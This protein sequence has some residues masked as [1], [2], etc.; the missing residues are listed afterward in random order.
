MQEQSFKKFPQ[1]KEVKSNRSAYRKGEKTKEE[2]DATIKNFIKECIK[3]QEELD[4]DVLVHGE[5]ERNDMVEFFGE[6][7]KGYV[8]TEKAW[9]QSYGT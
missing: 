2:Y 6:N 1:T 9:V 7:L 8:F 3:K 4:I 5:Y